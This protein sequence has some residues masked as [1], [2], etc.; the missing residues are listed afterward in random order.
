MSPASSS[1]SAWN[2]CPPDAAAADAALA[3]SASPHLH[4]AVPRPTARVLAAP[5]HL[6]LQPTSSLSTGARDRGSGSGM[7]GG[8]TSRKLGILFASILALVSGLFVVTDTRLILGRAKGR[9]LEASLIRHLPLEGIDHKE[10][11]EA[12]QSPRHARDVPQLVR[13]PEESLDLAGQLSGSPAELLAQ[14]PHES[15]PPAVRWSELG[16]IPL[17]S[18]GEAKQVDVDQATASHEHR[19]MEQTESSEVGLSLERRRA[20]GSEND[21]SSL[22]TSVDPLSSGSVG[23]RPTEPD[24]EQSGGSLA[25]REPELLQPTRPRTGVLNADSEDEQKA[26]ELVSGVKHRRKQGLDRRKR[27]AR[28]ERQ[29]KAKKRT[30]PGKHIGGDEAK[31]AKHRGKLPTRQSKLLLSTP[32]WYNP[33]LPREHLCSTFRL[34]PP[35]PPN[36][37]K[38]GPRPCPVCYLPLRE[39]L[40]LMPPRNQTSSRILKEISF[41]HAQDTSELRAKSLGK[42]PKFGGHPSWEDRADSFNIRE[43]MHV[44]CGFV[45]GE[46]PGLDSMYDIEETDRADMDKCESVTVASAIFGAYDMLQQPTN[47]SP[48]ARRDVCFFMFVD[49]ETFVELRRDGT[50][51]LDTNTAGLWRIVIVRNLPFTDPRRTGKVPKLLLHRLFPNTQFSLWVD[52]KL[53][54]VVDP[55][56]IL[57]R[58]LWRGNY[59]WAISKHYKRFDVFEEAEANKAAGKYDNASIDLQV[60]TYR[61]DGMT[62]YTEAKLPIISDVPEGCVIIR[63]HTPLSNLF[64]CLWFNEVDRFTSRDQL[65]F[66]YVRDKV[67]A[68]SDLR[69]NMFLDC[70]RRNFV[71]QAYHKDVLLQKASKEQAGGAFK[72]TADILQLGSTL[73]RMDLGNPK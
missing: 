4:A 38:T 42:A 20:I 65:S 21:S 11:I 66:G 7:R 44:H 67:L 70:E 28:A 73:D 71:V 16:E 53:Q 31:L 69:L 1:P 46:K 52:A 24:G 15:K 39:A 2:A 19:T 40:E 22:A 29:R 54:L 17:A 64:S 45:Y 36:G 41:A 33:S 56:K 72:N 48:K 37:R 58:F 23:L 68:K 30:G 55:Y 3:N 13:R 51:P 6:R 43:K 32:P 59:T 62:P 5:K 10:V 60:G 8:C 12:E 49:E 47:I 50:I 26:L 35:P 14:L 25:R 57:E 61:N 27:K 9:S 18:A 34:S 63:E